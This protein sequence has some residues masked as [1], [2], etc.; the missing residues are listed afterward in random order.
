ME[1]RVVAAIEQRLSIAMAFVE[2]GQDA[3][4]QPE[5]SYLHKVQ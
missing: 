2:T 5:P 1:G 3:S 4:T